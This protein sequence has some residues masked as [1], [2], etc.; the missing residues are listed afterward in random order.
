M[1]IKKNGVIYKK[2]LKLIEV[3][4]YVLFYQFLV[5]S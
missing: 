3:Q 5:L 4:C 2:Y 1:K